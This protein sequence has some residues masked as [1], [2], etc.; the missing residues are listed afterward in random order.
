MEVRY[1]ARR[2]KGMTLVG[3]TGNFSRVFAFRPEEGTWF[4]EQEDRA[5]QAV[6]IIGHDI[7]ETLFS[8]LDPLG[9][10]ILMQGKPFRVIG[11]MAKK[12]G[13]G[14]GLSHDNRVYVPMNAYRTGFSHGD[15]DFELECKAG[16]VA[17]VP[18]SQ[19]EVRTYI[20]AMR[21]TRFRAADPFGTVNQEMVMGLYRSITGAAF[22]V[23]VMV[24]AISLVVGGVVIMNI[25]LVSVT[26]RT[27]EI[28]IRRALGAR[29]ADIRRQ[30]LLEA[31]VLSGVGGAVGLLLGSLIIYL[32]RVATS[33][34]GLVTPGLALTSL[35]VST[36]VGLVAGYLPARRAS[37]LGVIDAIRSE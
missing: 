32:L 27:Q 18:A 5:G 25:M 30:F 33:F 16:S 28:G 31:A 37:N 7:Q 13:L 24:S 35:G 15:E 3:V 10:T 12:G 9:K 29:K 1:E 20:R 23:L 8:G 6:A 36:L 11:T 21:H 22:A 26:E 19:D 14:M 4:G 2:I 17:E 34:P